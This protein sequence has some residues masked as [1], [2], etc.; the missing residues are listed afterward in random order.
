MSDI[1]R[2]LPDAVANQI[3]AGE[4]VQRPASV[5][6]ELVENALDAGAASIQVIIKEAGKSL[7]QVIDDGKGMSENDARMSFERHATSKIQQASDLYHIKTMGFR[8]EAVASVAAVSQTELRTRLA[9]EEL[10]VRLQME[11]SELQELEP[12]AMPPGTSF[13][14][15]NLFFNVPARRNFLKSN[16]VEMR[17]IIEEFQRLAL[18]NPEV[19]F[20]LTHNQSELYK[21]P[22][23]NLSKRVVSLFGKNYKSQLINCKETIPHM[24]LGG[25]IGKPSFAKKTRGEQYIFVNKRF[26]KSSYLN[27]AIMQAYEGLLQPNTFPFY[28]LFI[29]IDPKHIDVNVHPTKT[30]IKFDDEKTVYSILK[31]TVRQSLGTH[32]VTPSLDFE[33]NINFNTSFV[34]L[35]VEKTIEQETLAKDRE[36]VVREASK[37]ERVFRSAAPESRRGGERFSGS[38]G[39]SFGGSSKSWENAFENSDTANL[40]GAYDA[41]LVPEPEEERGSVPEPESGELTFES[42]SNTWNEKSKEKLQIAEGDAMQTMQ[43]RNRWIVLQESRGMLLVD[44][45]EAHE[46]ILYERYAKQLVMH[47]GLSQQL[48][49]PQIIPLAPSE[50]YLVEELKDEIRSLGFVFELKENAGLEVSGVPSDCSDSEV[51]ELFEGLIE[52]IKINQSELSLTKQDSIARAM[53]KR[54]GIKAGVP[55]TPEEQCSL[56]ERLFACS[57]PNYSPSGKK[58]YHLLEDSA[59]GAWF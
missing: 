41:E 39:N 27:H 25:Y 42:A 49:F 8:G 4:V 12:C 7:I 47:S 18:A 17:H 32:G 10:G 55:L 14:V 22:V 56:V 57:N 36:Q 40:L 21:L 26:V 13:A 1:I 48:L 53:A 31:A 34:S 43:I 50:T 46:R 11:G 29:E 24:E 37:Q 23:S 2:L 19:G 5:V 45:Q 28:V 9:E 52:Q 59:I 54:S 30:E 20:S 35:D 51:K 58:T 6:K 3:A 33:S 44:Q 38:A 15:R 16:A